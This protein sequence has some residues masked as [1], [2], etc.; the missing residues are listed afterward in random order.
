MLLNGLFW[1]LEN[2]SEFGC[3]WRW[4]LLDLINVIVT[5]IMSNNEMVLGSLHHAV[6]FVESNEAES[7]EFMQE[8]IIIIL[9]FYT[10]VRNFI[11]ILNLEW[12]QKK[13]L[14]DAPI[15]CVGMTWKWHGNISYHNENILY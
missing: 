1:K 9:F 13:S 6:T 12:L 3:F 5:I 4:N 7:N 15:L 11:C 10:G 2:D 8:V 14:V